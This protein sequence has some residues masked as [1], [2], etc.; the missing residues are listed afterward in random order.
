[1]WDS[2]E[3]KGLPCRFDQ[4]RQLRRQEARYAST[5]VQLDSVGKH[6]AHPGAALWEYRRGVHWCLWYPIES[7]R[8]LCQGHSG[9]LQRAD[10]DESLQVRLSVVRSAP[11]PQR[12]RQ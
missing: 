5:H 6:K 11:C 3:A 7:R 10:A 8:D 4:T 1:M 9:F 12:R 2:V